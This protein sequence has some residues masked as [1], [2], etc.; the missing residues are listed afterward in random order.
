MIHENNKFFTFKHESEVIEGG[1]GSQELSVEGRLLLLCVR[2]LL[3]VEGQ[4]S[5]GTV[6]ELLKNCTQVGT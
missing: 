3:G 4:Q 2:E 1:V 6:Q 5:Q